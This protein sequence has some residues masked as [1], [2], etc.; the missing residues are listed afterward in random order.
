MNGD[1]FGWS[2]E[3][4]ERAR[5]V[6]EN[7]ARSVQNTDNT[8]P[9]VTAARCRNW[10][11][12]VADGEHTPHSMPATR[13]VSTVEKHVKGECQH[14]MKRAGLPCEYREGRGWERV[15]VVRER[16]K[17]RQ[18]V[19]AHTTR[20]RAFPEQSVVRV[21]ELGHPGV[22]VAVCQYCSGRRGLDG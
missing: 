11:N 5:K 9:A 3:Q 19:I 15:G 12:Y 17:D 16:D 8:T 2:E 10:R 13:A 18:H 14:T 20:C 22:E 4:Q 1:V 21:S 6:L 7:D